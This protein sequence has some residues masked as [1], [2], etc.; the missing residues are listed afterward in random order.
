[1]VGKHL[2]V[3]GEKPFEVVADGA[4]G[5]RERYEFLLKRGIRPNIPYY[6]ARSKRRSE[7]EEVGFVYDAEKGGCRCPAGKRLS[8]HIGC[9]APHVAGVPIRLCE[10][11]RPSIGSTRADSVLAEVEAYAR[12]KYW[13]ETMFGELKTSS[14]LRQAWLW[15]NWKVQVQALLAFAVR[16]INQMVRRRNG[17]E[18]G[19]MP[20]RKTRA[21]PAVSY[22][23]C[24]CRLVSVEQAGTAFGKSPSGVDKCQDSSPKINEVSAHRSHG[25]LCSPLRSMS[26]DFVCSS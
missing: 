24:C 8:I 14:G 7:K 4:H 20:C 1:V 3:T 16:D 19:T 6:N 12:R 9:T 11:K 21:P 25:V 10:A 15:G 17:P 23:V 22:V 5:L 26:R 2:V 18:A 13:V